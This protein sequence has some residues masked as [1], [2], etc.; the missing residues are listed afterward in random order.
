MYYFC[1][2]V[3]VLLRL[4]VKWW[5]SFYQ[6]F[7]CPRKVCRLLNALQC[8]RLFSV[9]FALFFRLVKIW[10]RYRFP[11]KGAEASCS[12]RQF[13]NIPFVTNV[14]ALN[15]ELNRFH[16]KPR[17]LYCVYL[18][19]KKG[20]TS[21]S[22]ILFCFAIS[23]AVLATSVCRIYG[24][25]PNWESGGGVFECFISTL[26]NLRFLYYFSA[27]SCCTLHPA[28]PL[29]LSLVSRGRAV[30]RTVGVSFRACHFLILQHV[31]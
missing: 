20:G 31:E 28:H 5:R 29:C 1:C 23:D 10:Q 30:C 4:K 9:E 3:F 18:M 21:A 11:S 26:T 24:L 6:G 13:R 15:C 27:L 19:P 8:W 16:Y 22:I 2:D 12:Q 17:L 25:H 7:F 14:L